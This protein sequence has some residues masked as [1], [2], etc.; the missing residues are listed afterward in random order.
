MLAAMSN[1]I[2]HFSVHLQRLR[3]GVVADFIRHDD[4]PAWIEL[5]SSALLSELANSIRRKKMDQFLASREQ[6]VALARRVLFSRRLEWLDSLGPLWRAFGSREDTCALAAAA[7]QSASGWTPEVLVARAGPSAVEFSP[8]HAEFVETLRKLA[9]CDHDGPLGAAVRNSR[10]LDEE[11]HVGFP[12]IFNHGDVNLQRGVWIEPTLLSRAVTDRRVPE[13]ERL[14]ASLDGMITVKRFPALPSWL[15]DLADCEATLET[16]DSAGLSVVMQSLAEQQRL[17]LPFGVGFT[18]RWENDRLRGV[19]DL[20]VKA[21]AARE[22]GVFLLFACHDDKEEAPKAVDGVKLVLLPEHL[23]L[24]EVIRLVNRTC[25]ESGLTEYRFRKVDRA[26]RDSTSRIGASRDLPDACNDEYC[27]V[28]FVGRARP[29]AKL[30]KFN[31][32][33]GQHAGRC[34]LA[35]VAP[36][37]FGK[38]TLLSH[39]GWGL[40]DSN[41][42]KRPFP[43]IWFSFRRGRSDRMTL[44][45]L[46]SALAEQLTARF[47]VLSRHKAGVLRGVPHGKPDERISA[48]IESAAARIDLLV[49][50]IDEVAGVDESG[51]ILRWLQQLS[52]DGVTIVGT[53]PGP[54]LE[55]IECERLDLRNDTES[56]RTDALELIARFANRFEHR[57]SLR[58]IAEQLRQD[59][60]RDGLAKKAGDNLCSRE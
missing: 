53:Q 46:K 29:L 60:W 35:V 28:Q 27:P 33:A 21:L 32:E 23:P 42:A 22:A 52:G 19:R 25:A 26:L 3:R 4:F 9:D 15:R 30:R 36:P 49:D 2:D 56:A 50:G 43:P 55:R 24:D 57:E 58:P 45:H 38:T 39:W 34:L 54:F 31:D 59:R 40:G 10:L 14:C 16:L 47:C 1:R 12:I 17:P 20:G 11:R 18:G 6:V 48:V 41:E 8:A 13:W 7:L 5:T 51:K 37:R 44:N